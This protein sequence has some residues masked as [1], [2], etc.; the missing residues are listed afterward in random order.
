YAPE[1]GVAPFIPGATD[2]LATV[3]ELLG[4]KAGLATDG[5]LAFVL[6][7]PAAVGSENMQNALMV[8]VP[9]TDYR[10]FIGN[11]PDART[12]GNVTTFTFP[13][14]GETAYASNWGSFAVLSPHPDV[15]SLKPAGFKPSAVTAKELEKDIVLL[16]NVQ[17]LRSKLQ[18]LLADGRTQLGTTIEEELGREAP[19]MARFVPT[20][21]LAV[22]R[23][24][25]VAD[26]FLRDAESATVALHVVPEGLNVSITSEFAP[27]SYLGAYAS[28]ATNSTDTFT[29]GLPAGKYLLYGGMLW[30]PVHDLKLINDLAGPVLEELKKVGGPEAEAIQKFY[31]DFEACFSAM[32]GQRFGMLAPQGEIGNTAMMQAVSIYSGDA[33]KMKSSYF[34]M[35]E[36]QGEL[37]SALGLGEQMKYVVNRDVK[38]IDGVA[39]DQVKAEIKFDANSP[40]AAQA[41]QMMKMLYGPEGMTFYVTAVG[42]D[43]VLQTFGLDDAMMSQALAAAKGNNDTL[44]VLPQ[45]KLVANQLPAR[46][47]GVFYVAL[48]EITTTALNV[49]RQFGMGVNVQIQPDLPPLGASFATEGSALRVDVHAPTQLVS[50]LIAAGFQIGMQMGQGGPKRGGPGGL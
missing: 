26:S 22:N 9:V 38:S 7:D 32:T 31:N 19:E 29:T 25:D 8:L 13:N 18:P 6:V 43:K 40:D 48:D 12:E 3:Q 42:S 28:S 36:G 33:G 45:V 41:E 21:K 16:A 50:Q 4:I 35:M 37:M 30:D 1:L 15:H 20:I 14:G 44:G 5:E 2:P 49:A 46:K 34:A 17:N 47:S 23:L 11:W 10:A 27:D 24:I 39:F